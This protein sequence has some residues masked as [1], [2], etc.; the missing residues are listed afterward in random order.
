MPLV[1]D[2]PN[3]GGQFHFISI[4]NPDDAKDRTARRLARSH[5]V[6]R[7]L[8]NKRKLQQKSGLNFRV[9]SLSDDNGRHASKRPRS[10]TLQV[11][12][13]PRSVSADAPS[14]FRMLAAESPRLLALLSQHQAQQTREPVFS[15]SDELVL[16]NFRSVLRKGLDDHA[17]VSAVMLTFAFTV[18]AGSVDMEYLGYQSEALSSLRQRMSSPDRAISESTLG[19]ILLLAGIEARLGMPHQV[20]LHM[21]AIQQL[22]DVCRT[23]GVYLSDGIKRAIFWQDLNSSVLT[24]SSRVVDHTTFSELHWTRDAC[25]PDLFILP[26][27]FKA[28]SHLLGDEFVEVLKDLHALQRI[29]DSADPSSPKDMI[30][31]ARI[32]NHQAFIQS[33]LV[34]LPIRSPIS[35]A[36]RVAAYLCSTMLRCK[37]WPASTIPSHISARLLFKLKECNDDPIWDDRPDLLAWLLHIGGAFAPTKTIRSNYVALLRSNR[38][39][40]LRD[41]YT[42]WPELLETL[43]R[44]IWS[45]KAFASPVKAFWEESSF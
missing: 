8:E 18:G 30:S 22:L 44:F 27:G 15:V 2:E 13:S 29:R 21:S 28:Q 24:G 45:E 5:A 31:M 11:V 41:L 36:C 17:L 12:A 4:Q 1:R 37:L 32:D 42:S 19:A 34:R 43:K 38:S 25:S 6:A 9:V 10:Q 7:S 14:L 40:R 33:R 23:K 20:Q 3:L 35:E 39:T 26:S 16:Q